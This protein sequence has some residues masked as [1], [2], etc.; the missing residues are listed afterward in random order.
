[1]EMTCQSWK[2]GTEEFV[3]HHVLADYIQD[4]AMDNG[5][6]D[7]ISFNTRVNQVRKDDVGWEIDVA[8]LKE[9]EGEFTVTND[10]HVRRYPD[11]DMNRHRLMI[12][13][14]RFD[15]NCNRPLSCFQRS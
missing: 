1:M 7:D 13:A 15:S 10:T 12:A 4:S 3:P 5:I 14:F 6:L 9:I 2:D 11:R 8:K